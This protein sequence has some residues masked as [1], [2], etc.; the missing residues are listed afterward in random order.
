MCSGG[1][2]FSGLAAKVQNPFYDPTRG[3]VI[4]RASARTRYSARKYAPSEI[5][6]PDRSLIQMGEALSEAG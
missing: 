5:A 2:E 6:L 3:Q 1:K 4:A